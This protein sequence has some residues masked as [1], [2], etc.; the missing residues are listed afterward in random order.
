[1]S[2]MTAVHPALCRASLAA[3]RG[4]PDSAVS[5]PD[6]ALLDLPERAVQFGTGAF[7]RGFVDDFLHRANQA[8]LFDGRVVVVG[9]T[10]SGRDGALRAQDGLYTLAVEG[11]DEGHPVQ[12][13][14]IIASVSR[15]L[16][17]T[18][19]WDAVLALARAPLVRFVFSNTTE[20]GIALHPD[21]AADAAPP[22]S[23]PAKLTRFLYER[24]RAFDFDAAYGLT[25]IPCELIERN[26][27]RLRDL[28]RTLADSWSLDTR[29]L[30]W[31]AGSVQFCNTLVDRIVPGTPRGED[32]RRLAE[33]LGYDDQLLTTC[34]PYRLFAIEG[35]AALRERLTWAGVDASIVIAADIA[36]YRERKVRLLNGAHTILVTV[37]LALGCETVA[38][39]VRHPLAGPFVRRVMFDEIA[40]SLEAPDASL[41]A[42]QVINRFHN[43]FIRHALVDITLQNTMKMRVRVVPSIVAHARR[44]GHVPAS[45][46]FGFAAFLDFMRGELRAQRLEH[47]RPLPPDDG[48]STLLALWHGLPDRTAT[49][50]DQLVR[51]A[52]ADEKL[53]GADLAAVQGFVVLV[54]AH[55]QRILTAGMSV[56]LVEHLSTPAT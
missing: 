18:D 21:D 49:S 22:R 11:F 3:L 44:T 31:L 56:A 54:S 33:Q 32:A 29:F 55:L 25:V 48:A 13:C 15:A 39:A 35:G 53:W 6:E 20:V 41:F 5:V 23:F 38:E 30:V 2:T 51:E 9:S 50:I 26:G 14:R 16:S 36:P 10:G 45:L 19:E 42:E 27:D 40:P 34:E 1:M 7:L 12:E 43:P 52:C 17:A 8:G 46:A 4:A 37:A 28:V 24:A 47:G